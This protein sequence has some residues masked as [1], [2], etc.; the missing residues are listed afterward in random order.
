M[1]QAFQAHLANELAQIKDASSYKTE[2]ILHS[3]QSAHVALG[4][5]SR[6]PG[7]REAEDREAGTRAPGDSGEV[8]NL[9]ANNYLGLANHSALVQA[10]KEG[11][12]RWGFGLSSVRFICGTQDV[13]KQLEGTISRFMGYEDTIL[14]GSCFDANGALF[15]AILGPEDAVLSDALNHA[16]IIDGIRLSKAQRFRYAHSDMADLEVKLKEASGARHRLVF[17]D[18]VFSMDGDVAK[19]DQ[20]CD[21]AERY[22]AIV[23]VDDCHATGVLG[24]TGRGSGEAKGVRER[25]AVVTGTLGKALGGASGG[26]VTG[27]REIVEILR[28]RGR[29][30]LF[31]NALMPAIAHASIEAFRLVDES[32]AL[33]DTLR[34]NAAAF[35][36][37]LTQAGFRIP[38]GETPIV[39]ILI[40]DAGKTQAMAEAMLDEGIYVIGFS[41][42]VVPVGQDRIRTQMSAAHT[43]ADLDRAIDAFAR[44]GTQIGVIG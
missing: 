12:D 5:G 15:E 14:F 1:F 29:P 7:V 26:Y 38:P 44:V 18:G 4:P 37:G 39:P 28:Q 8:L 41:Y 40:G 24:K 27:R 36:A 16:S 30:Y 31:S 10:A 23:G 17:T 9:C 25:I 13:H 6:G 43:K 21:L 11:L 2:R 34:E 33:L 35:R 20:I 19:L 22:D 3:P 32:P 42:P